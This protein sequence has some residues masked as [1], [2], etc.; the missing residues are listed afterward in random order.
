MLFSALLCKAAADAATAAGPLD[1]EAVAEALQP[2]LDD[3]YQE[4]GTLP[5]CM[6]TL[7]LRFTVGGED[8][9]VRDLRWVAIAAAHVQE[10]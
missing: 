10:F 8:G 7:V 1:D 9:S 5:Q 2:V 4:L 3:L 6:G